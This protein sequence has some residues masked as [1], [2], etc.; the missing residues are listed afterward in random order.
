MECGIVLPL[1]ILLMPNRPESYEL[2]TDGAIFRPLQVCGATTD[3]SLVTSAAATQ[4]TA[5]QTE[6]Q[7]SLKVDVDPENLKPGS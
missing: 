7:S 1:A 6:M 5:I 3:S 2:E 4:S